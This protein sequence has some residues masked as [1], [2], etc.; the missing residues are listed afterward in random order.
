MVH[1]PGMLMELVHDEYAGPTYVRGMVTEGVPPHV[2]R[3][4]LYA[5]HTPLG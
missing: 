1:D 3:E 5:P 4:V 2:G